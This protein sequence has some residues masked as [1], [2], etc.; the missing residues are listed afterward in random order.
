MSAVEKRSVALSP[1]L[2][3]AVDQAVASGDYGSASEVIRDALQQW[4]ERRALLGHSVEE[5]RQLWREGVAD[6]TS[7]PFSAE[8][9]AG[10]R[11]AALRRLSDKHG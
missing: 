1:E 9:M 2:A 11:A 4:Q 10:V 8:T 3:E 7:K 6:G 5:L